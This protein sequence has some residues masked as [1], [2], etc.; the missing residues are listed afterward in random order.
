[1]PQRKGRSR[2][3]PNRF[4]TLVRK[5]LSIAVMVL[6]GPIVVHFLLTNFISLRILN[7]GGTSVCDSVLSFR[8]GHSSLI[9]YWIWPWFVLG[10]IIGA[11][12]SRRQ[13]QAFAISLR[14]LAAP[15]FGLLCALVFSYNPFLDWGFSKPN[16]VLLHIYIVLR[17]IV[18]VYA[19]IGLP[20]AVFLLTHQ[21]K[22]RRVLEDPKRFQI[23]AGA[24]LLSYATTWDLVRSHALDYLTCGANG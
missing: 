5:G 8:A 15:G 13:G 17:S 3:S 21:P 14:W 9:V 6:T 11:V 24:I 23:I 7:R 1:M 19:P 16:I 10:A 12:Y 20:F 22:W 2:M 18:L 4:G